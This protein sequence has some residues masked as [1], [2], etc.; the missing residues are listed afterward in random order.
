MGKHQ[1]HSKV[2]FLKSRQTCVKDLLKHPRLLGAVLG[3]DGEGGSTVAMKGRG[4][5]L[6]ITGCFSHSIISPLLSDIIARHEIKISVR[7]C[8]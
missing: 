1:G 2:L 3:L 8:C 4:F 6:G 7:T 5:Y